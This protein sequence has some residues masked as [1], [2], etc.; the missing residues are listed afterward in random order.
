MV[1]G[2]DMLRVT[3]EL[4][5]CG[6]EGRRELLATAEIWR[7]GGTP[8]R[9]SYSYRFQQVRSRRVWREGRVRGFP[10]RRRSAWYLV[11]ACIFDVFDT[12]FT[13]G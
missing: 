5:P 12:A 6:D 13:C 3:V 2:V 1:W 10:R 9:G 7:D 4:V 11:A 8:N